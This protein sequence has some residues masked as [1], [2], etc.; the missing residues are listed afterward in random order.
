MTTAN[1]IK[2]GLINSIRSSE[3]DIIIP[4]FYYGIYE[5]DVFH[6]IN[7][8]RLIN[9]Y[10]I[11]TSRADF[12]KDFDK[13]NGNKHSMLYKGTCRCNRF[14]YVVP[15]GL[16]KVQEVPEYAGLMYAN[17]DHLYCSI[18]IVKTAPFIHKSKPEPYVFH[19]LAVQLARR[20]N[21]LHNKYNYSV[22]QRNLEK[23]SV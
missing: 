12:K 14:Y 19:H 11:K 15:E 6:M 23:S 16:I 3:Y 18:T 9:E 2:Y 10:E 21:S 13:G 20:Y 17:I 8:S 1:I 22:Y 5:M 4:N 7:P